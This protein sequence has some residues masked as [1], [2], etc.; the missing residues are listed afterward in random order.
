M[1]VHSMPLSMLSKSIVYKV[2]KGM[3]VDVIKVKIGDIHEKVEEL[4]IQKIKKQNNA[5]CLCNLK[6]LPCI[7]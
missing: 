1:Y 5:V 7:L 3:Y 2:M 4:S 6:L